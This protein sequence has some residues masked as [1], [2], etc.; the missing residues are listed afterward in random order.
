LE[1]VSLLEQLSTLTVL[2]IAENELEEVACL[3]PLTGLNLKRL[4]VAGNPM[5]EEA[6]ADASVRKMFASL[7]SLDSV[8]LIP[9]KGTSYGDLDMERAR[10]NVKDILYD[11]CDKS[12]CTCL[13]GNACEKPDHCADW[14]QR[15]E[16]ARNVRDSR[17]TS[18]GN[19]GMLY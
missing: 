17:V 10:R 3:A 7:V 14:E 1:D 13:V 8:S 2:C 6:R 18:Q 4:C 9:A 5:L 12:C 19:I 16:V 15:F 11:N